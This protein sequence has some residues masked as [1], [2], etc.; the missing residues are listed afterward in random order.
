MPYLFTFLKPRHA[1]YPQW[2]EMRRRRKIEWIAWAAWIPVTMLL[3][4]LVL[5][6]S[7][8]LD[9]ELPMLLTAAATMIALGVVRLWRL[10]WPCPKCGR[11]FASSWGISSLL[12]DSCL[13]CGLP[14]YAPC[15]PAKQE[16]EFESQAKD[17]S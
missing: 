4:L 9:T 8:A 12:S 15:D 17:V 13:H 3:A 2:L 14:R 6:L 10:R 7:M 16:W 1:Y 11:P 5:P